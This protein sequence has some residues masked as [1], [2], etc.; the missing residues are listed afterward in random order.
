MR[1]SDKGASFQLSNQTKMYL[2]PR[3]NGKFDQS[4]PCSIHVRSLTANA[5]DGG[6]IPRGREAP[7]N[8]PEEFR[9]AMG[10]LREVVQKDVVYQ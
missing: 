7:K 1:C 3:R 2:S 4:L 8:I 10:C 6:I 9:E 5:A